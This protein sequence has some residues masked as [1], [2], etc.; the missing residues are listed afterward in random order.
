MA[1]ESD[2]L[3]EAVDSGVRL[4]VMAGARL[5]SEIAPRPRGT[6]PRATPHRRTRR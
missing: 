2:G 6:D 5:G 4:A 1:A 3:E